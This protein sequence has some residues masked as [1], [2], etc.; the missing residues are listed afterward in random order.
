MKKIKLLGLLMATLSLGGCMA[1]LN[2]DG[3]VS[4][5]YIAPEVNRVVIYDRPS[6][7][8]IVHKPNHRPTYHVRNAH[9]PNRG[10][11]HPR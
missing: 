2:P 7:P 3:T 11:H 9:R 10:R 4:A 6:R 5:G 8:I 1:T